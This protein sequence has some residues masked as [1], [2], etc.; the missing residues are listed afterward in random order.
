[1]E[2]N[3]MYSI[4]NC[5]FS[6]MKNIMDKVQIVKNKRQKNLQNLKVRSKKMT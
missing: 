2:I 1:V 3:L 4:T 6:K 5:I